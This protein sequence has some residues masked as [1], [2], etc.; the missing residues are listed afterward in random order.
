MVV[1][2]YQVLVP[3]RI[4]YQ[5]TRRWLH[6]YLTLCPTYMG[7]AQVAYDFTVLYLRGEIERILTKRRMYPTKQITVAEMWIKL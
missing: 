3:R 5:A 4:Y 1:S 7:I 2:D 6:I